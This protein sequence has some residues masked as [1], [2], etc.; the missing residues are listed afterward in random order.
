MKILGKKYFHYA[1]F[2]FPIQLLLLHIKKHPLLLMFWAV[3]F[4]FI[5]QFLGVNYGIPLLFFEPEYLDN[6]NFFSFLVIGFAMGGF[7]TAWNISFYILNSYRFEFLASSVN[8]FVQFCL[9]NSIIPLA[10][11]IVYIVKIVQF[12]H[13]ENFLSTTEILKNIGALLLGNILMV[14]AVT[15]LFLFFNQDVETFINKLSDKA[16]ESLLGKKIHLDKMQFLQHRDE[17][18]KVETFLTFPFK[19]KLVRKVNFY[20]RKLV[21][22]VLFLHH[23][24]AFVFQFVCI[25]GLFCLGFF[26]E[27]PYFRL[28]AVAAGFIIFSVATVFFSFLS[29]FFRGWATVAFLFFI[30]LLNILTKYDLVVYK[31]KFFGL[32]Y[33]SNKVYYNNKTVNEASNT[34]LINHDIKKTTL[35]LNN[36][37]KKNKTLYGNEK[38]KLILINSAGGGLKASYWTFHV[39]QELEKETH[40][41]LFNHTMLL[42]GASGGMLGAAYF[43]EL[44]LRK[45]QNEAVDYLHKTYLDDIGKDLLNGIITSIATNDIFYPWRSYSYN[46]FEY[47]KDRAFIFN[48]KL[49]ENTHYMMFKKLNE[50]KKPEQQS[51]IPMMVLGAT[52][53]NDQRFLLFSPNQISYLTKPY[54]SNTEKYKDEFIAD[55]VEFNYFFR[56][57]GAP[58][59]N[60]I[61]ALRTNATYPYLMPAVYLPTQPEIKAMDAG[62]RDNSGFTISTRFYSVFK[63]WIEENTSGV[64][65]IT[66]RVGSKQ[67][68]YNAKEKDSYISELLAPV[69]NIFNNF[70]LLQDYN[71]DLALSYLENTKNSNID[72]LTFNY[73][74]SEKRK[75]ASMSWHLTD[76]EKK[77]IQDAFEQMNNQYM[78]KKLKVLLK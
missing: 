21:E 2:S 62:I 25:I 71:S 45:K 40:Q 77:D 44:Y 29:F 17:Q 22:R 3:L 41:K 6:V 33:I 7:I 76:L 53:I 35:I 61:D 49:N 43:R 13:L 14:I 32:D 47:K 42:T 54:F 38:P 4:G 5:L 60:F 19:I 36:W 63:N 74:Q 1:F 46:G 64:I 52:I 48:K 78:L 27:N 59:I 51:K 72:V 30:I 18:W 34:T 10:F 57:K 26:I 28:P 31:H 37:L 55:A 20:D 75:K 16:K 65:F 39:L 9:N 15:T 50:Y 73:D 69:G 58:S 66:I 56:D 12:Q 70:L 11:T 68:K 67:R 24:F 23:R 8:P